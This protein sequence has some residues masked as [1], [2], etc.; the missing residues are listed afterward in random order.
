M[1]HKIS[2]PRAPPKIVKTRQYKYYNNQLF[3]SDLREIFTNDVYQSEDPNELWNDWNTRFLIV[4]DKHAPPITRK[5][6]SEYSP[7]LTSNITKQNAA[8]RL[9][10][11]TS[12]SNR[13]TSSPSSIQTWHVTILIN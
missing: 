6:R 1:H 13:F 3:K 7:W 11:E 5:V 12:N 9:S 2:I 4:A 8:S 10:E